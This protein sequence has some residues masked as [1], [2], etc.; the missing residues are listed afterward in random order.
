[1]LPFPINLNQVHIPLP[2]IFPLPV[3][4]VIILSSKNIEAY[5]NLRSLQHQ[6]PSSG[7]A[8]LQPSSRR[9][10]KVQCRDEYTRQKQPLRSAADFRYTLSEE[11]ATANWPSSGS[12]GYESRRREYVARAAAMPEAEPRPPTRADL[13]DRYQILEIIG[14]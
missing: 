9:N 13:R 14:N 5:F 3:R 4:T 12:Q 2:F 11:V 10:I 6:Q 1:M 8:S 7:P